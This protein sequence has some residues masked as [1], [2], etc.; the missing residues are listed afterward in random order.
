MSR[1][2][3]VVATLFLNDRVTGVL[4]SVLLCL[5]LTCTVASLFPALA[6]V[7][8]ERDDRS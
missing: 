3:E 6:T 4:D 1:V 2:I 8:S 5:G 7:L